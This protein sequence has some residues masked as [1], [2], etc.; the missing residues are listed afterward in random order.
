MAGRGISRARNRYFRFV[1]RVKNSLEGQ[2]YEA[3]EI[4]EKLGKAITVVTHTLRARIGEKV[5]VCV[6]VFERERG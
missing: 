6:C 4:R 3:T 5:C 1:Y 2:N